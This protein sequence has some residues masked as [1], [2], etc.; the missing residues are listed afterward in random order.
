MGGACDP[1]G[2]DRYAL[3]DRRG[4]SYEPYAPK[5]RL[6]TP[7]PRLLVFRPCRISPTCGRQSLHPGDCDSR[8][9]LELIEVPYEQFI[10]QNPKQKQSKTMTELLP[11]PRAEN[12]ASSLFFRWSKIGDTV[13]GKFINYE[14][15]A[16]QFK[17]P[18]ITLKTK[19]GKKLVS[20]P[21]DLQ[22]R[23][24]GPAEAGDLDGKWLR[25]AFIAEQEIKGRENKMKKFKV[26]CFE[27][28]AQAQVPSVGREPG[29]DSEEDPFEG[30]ASGQR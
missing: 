16:G 18:E 11:K 8:E 26:E 4:D 12:D 24:E 2:N 9:P 1:Y 17:K 29:D 21:R 13:V 28:E 30:R 20:A 23:I 19:D 25:I 5:E 6:Y 7:S 22:D 15:E 27:S 10:R 14:K 3:S